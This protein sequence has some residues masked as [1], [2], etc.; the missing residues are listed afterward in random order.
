MTAA[1]MRRIKERRRRERAEAYRKQLFKFRLFS[2]A[3]FMGIVGFMY[4]QFTEKSC[5]LLNKFC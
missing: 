4:Y 1:M 5:Q 2:L 3:L